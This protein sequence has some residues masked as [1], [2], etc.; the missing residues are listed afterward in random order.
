MKFE[1][2]PQEMEVIAKKIVDSAYTVHKT[3]GT[4]FW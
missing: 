2:I 3:V 1:P 4:G